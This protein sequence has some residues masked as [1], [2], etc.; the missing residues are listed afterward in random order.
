[1]FPSAAQVL[2]QVSPEPEAGHV[3]GM[4]TLAPVISPGE[5]AGR[6]P[7]ASAWSPSDTMAIAAT[8]DAGNA[9]ITARGRLFI[10]GFLFCLNGR[11][12][13]ASMPGWVLPD[14]KS[15]GVVGHVSTPF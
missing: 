4:P 7:A 13:C 3:C 10:S 11:V 2:Y 15:S 12:I 14:N 1:M 5:L 6:A 8:S 9:A